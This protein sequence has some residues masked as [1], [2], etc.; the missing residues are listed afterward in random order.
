MAAISIPKP[1]S[2]AGPCLDDCKHIDCAELKAE[3]AAACPLC[4]EPIGYGRLFVQDKVFGKAHDICV[5]ERLEADA[6]R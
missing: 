4:G 3:A 1:G 6:G 5:I 2:S